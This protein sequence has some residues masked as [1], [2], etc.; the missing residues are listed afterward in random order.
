MLLRHAPSG[1]ADDGRRRPLVLVEDATLDL[2]RLPLDGAAD[3]GIDVVVCSGP[4]GAGDACPLVRGG[5]C[6]AGRPDLVVTAL[7]GPWR[8]Y[9]ES[10]WLD[11][12]VP[13]IDAA[14]TAAWPAHVGIA[15]AALL[16]ATASDDPA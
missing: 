11:A 15:L 4:Q 7:Q 1:D 16:R 3:R 14:P 9:V 6:P 13:V 5:H 10:A 12:G 8:D 2:A